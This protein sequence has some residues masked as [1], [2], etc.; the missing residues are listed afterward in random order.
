MLTESLPYALPEDLAD[1]SATDF[2]KPPRRPE[3]LNLDADSGLGDIV[4]R[5]LCRDP[6]DRY[7][8]AQALLAE[9]EA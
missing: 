4:M 3:E 6:C 2:C 1:I 7:P 8:D 9:L 5:C